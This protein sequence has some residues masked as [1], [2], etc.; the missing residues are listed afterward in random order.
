MDEGRSLLAPSADGILPAA[1]ALAHQGRGAGLTPDDQAKAELARL[2]AARR[3][4]RAEAKEAAP[5]SGPSASGTG[6]T[7]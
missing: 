5:T 4:W 6:R 3:H 1:C 7:L 2:R